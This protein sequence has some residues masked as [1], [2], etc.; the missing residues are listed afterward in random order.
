M[1]MLHH[2]LNAAA[3]TLLGGLTLICFVEVL[4]RDLAGRSLGWYDELTGFL[5]VWLTFVGAPLAQIG[6]GHIAAELLRSRLGRGAARWQRTLVHLVSLAVQLILLVFGAQLAM[7]SR[8]ERAVTVDLSMGLFYLVVP[9]S[10]SLGIAIHLLQ[11]A[12]LWRAE[13]RAGEGRLV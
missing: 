11:I 1:N 13:A 12:R 2:A 3:A 10:A 7:Q 9:L 4:L 8:A 5:L 6:E